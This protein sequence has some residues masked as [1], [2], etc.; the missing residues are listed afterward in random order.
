MSAESPI[1]DSI[2]KMIFG[3]LSDNSLARASISCVNPPSCMILTP[4]DLRILLA[5]SEIAA[6]PLE[7]FIPPGRCVT[8]EEC[9]FTGFTVGM[10]YRM[11]GRPLLGLIDS[12][13]AHGLGLSSLARLE[14][15]SL[16]RNLLKSLYQ[17]PEL[18]TNV[19]GI[20][21]NHPLGIAAGFDKKAQAL[22]AWP[23]L[24][25]S[26]MEY[27]GITRYPQD[28]NPKP[29][30]FRANKE[31]ALINRMGFNN[32]GASAVRDNLIDRKSIGLWPDNP[33]A[34]NIGRSKKVSNDEA[35]N[36]YSSTLDILWDYSDLFVLNVS[37][38]NTPGLRE[39]QEAD[40]LANVLDSCNLIRD[41]KGSHK[42]LLLKFSPDM[43]DEDLLISAEVAIKSKIDG[44]VATNTT[45]SRYVPKNSQ[46]RSAFA[47]S[48]GL[49]GRPL[50]KRSL[51]V[52]NL[53]YSHTGSEVPIV[54]VGGIDSVESA[55]DMIIS[56]ASLIQLYSA[57][58]FNG[59]SV[60]SK[61]IK[62]LKV[63][64]KENN[65]S[66]IGEAVGSKHT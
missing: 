42:P 63:K 32:P 8:L 41:R 52:V 47:E 64:V 6:S 15:S 16:G 26:W 54:G 19:F 34:A 1:S 49:S 12:E 62:G 37:S 9:R 44:F 25:F 7:P 48:G 35:A 22:S 14:R 20:S 46:S 4:V 40:H 17:S 39:L 3:A 55:W 57:L 33:V 23:S 38:P 61:I 65:F 24:G 27:G 51:E 28:G 5:N 56:G 59:P 45:I 29:R 11:F 31:N 21:F 10:P 53:L 50:R 58:V 13:R 66:N 18:P 36:D 30:M 60:V 43:S 2:P